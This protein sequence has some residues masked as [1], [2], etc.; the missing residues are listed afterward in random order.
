[1]QLISKIEKAEALAHIDAILEASDGLMVARG[2][3]GV[4]MDGAQVTLI[5]QDLVRRCEGGGKPVIVATQM[6]QSMIEAS[7]PTRAEVSDVANAIFD[8]T[9]AVMLSGETSV[10]KY[11]IAAVHTMSHVAEVTE[12]YLAEREGEARRQ[13][14]APSM[15]LSVAVARGVWQIAHDLKVK[16]VCLWSQSGA[17]ARVFSNGRF[18]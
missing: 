5:Q 11:P 12:Q 18:P 15:R 17:T 4:E 14:A 13:V 3:L 6:L 16:L 2:D 7:S 8:G 1:I 10:G 9:D